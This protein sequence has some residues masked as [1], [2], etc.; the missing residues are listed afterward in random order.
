MACGAS[1][2]ADISAYVFSAG[3]ATFL[4]GEVEF[5]SGSF[6]FDTATDTESGVSITLTS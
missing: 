3:A 6:T 1:G 2:S 4:G 5:I